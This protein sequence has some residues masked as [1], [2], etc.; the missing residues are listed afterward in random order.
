LKETPIAYR[1]LASAFR[2]A[3]GVKSTSMVRQTM[4][5]VLAGSKKHGASV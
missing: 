5:F 1:I 4:G 2:R 3:I